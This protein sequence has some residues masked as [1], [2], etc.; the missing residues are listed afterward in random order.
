MVEK[1]RWTL[2]EAQALARRLDEAERPVDLDKR[3]LVQGELHPIINRK[4]R[5]GWTHKAVCEELA[6][7]GVEVAPSTLRRY[8]REAKTARR[9]RKRERGAR[10]PGAQSGAPVAAGASSQ[11]A[12]IHSAG[13]VNPPAAEG[14]IGRSKTGE[15]AGLPNFRTA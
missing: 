9:P 4:L 6:Q 1:H 14:D 11:S 8:L 7:L 13:T 3:S 12:A 10:V 2:E 5:Q 15:G